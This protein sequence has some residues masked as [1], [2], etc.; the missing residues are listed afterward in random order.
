MRRLDDRLAFPLALALISVFAIETGRAFD[1]AQ[2]GAGT[3][4]GRPAGWQV[5]PDAGNAKDQSISFVDM[6]PG[7]HITTSPAVVL[8]RAGLGASGD[9]TLEAELFLFPKATGAAGIVLGGSGLDGGSPRWVALLA[10]GDGQFAIEERRGE[11]TR[12]V[13]AWSAAASIVRSS[14]KGPGRN[15]LRVRAIGDDL[16][17]QIND[18]EVAAHPRSALNVDGLVGLRAGA[19]ANIHVT[20]LT[21]QLGGR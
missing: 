14:E 16:V 19:D 21:I 3:V 6:R 4:D 18:A 8:Y 5:R 11:T 10:R 13:Q 20:S 15:V 7:W 17:F 12:T 2:A 1:Q 9:F